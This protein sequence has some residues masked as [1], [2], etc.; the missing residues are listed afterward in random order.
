MI[1][2][3]G[4]AGFIG[5]CLLA[6]FLAEGRTDLLIADAF[7]KPEK[8]KNLRGKNCRARLDRSD[9]PAWMD[10]HARDISFVFHLGARTDTA[11]TRSSLFDELNLHYSQRIW[12]RCARYGIPLVYASSAATYGKG[13]QGFRDD[14]RLVPSL[15]PLNAYGESKQA[16][17]RWVLKQKD[18]PPFW[19]GL[20]F[21]N[22]Y[23]PNEYHKGRMASVVYHAH[24]QIC[25]SG[26]I[27]LFRSHKAA[28]TDG[29]QLRDFIYVKDVVD[30][31]LW[32]MTH[33]PPSG[34]YNLGSGE[35]RSFND[36]ARSVF[37]ALRLPV[38][39]SYTDMPAD[40]RDNY[41]YYTRAD[42]EKL[43]GVG[44]KNAWRSLEEGV[45]EYVCEYLSESRHL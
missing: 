36:L 22:V 45:T 28:F 10:A 39:I 4:A 15:K 31:C 21:F 7:G 23:G 8:E 41:Q 14:H 27:Q 33:T 11:E 13:E 35:A 40:I 44:Y 17:D 25:Q 16:F 20:K 42:M 19:A 26:S 2:L 1:V 32:M 29:E 38:Q 5:S 12:E 37:R 43:H 6:K 34:I 30:V 3:T 24:R 9:L 18:Q